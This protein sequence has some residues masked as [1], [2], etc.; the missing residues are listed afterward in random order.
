MGIKPCAEEKK[1]RRKRQVGLLI[2]I[3]CFQC[4]YRPRLAPSSSSR[5]HSL[6]FKICQVTSHWRETLEHTQEDTCIHHSSR[7]VPQILKDMPTQ[8][9]KLKDL[10]Q[11]RHGTV[12]ETKDRKDKIALRCFPRHMQPLRSTLLKTDLQVLT[13][14]F[15]GYI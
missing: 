7:Q 4:G 3:D 10:Q 2:K 15:S 1:H 12:N 11:R 5:P 14:P 9:R 13:T 6:A 8:G